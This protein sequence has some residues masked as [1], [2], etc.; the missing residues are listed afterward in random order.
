MKKLLILSVCAG[1]A[2][3]GCKKK[4]SAISTLYNHSVPTIILPDNHYYSI[5]VGGVLPAIEATAYDSFYH[6]ECAV[7]YDQSKLD[8]TIPDA[9]KVYATAQNKYGMMS[10][11]LLYVAVTD[12]DP[13]IDLSGLYARV[14]NDDTVM[15]TRLANGFYM[16][17]DVGANG[18]GDTTNIASAYFVQTSDV[19]LSMP[20]QDTKFGMLSG[21]GGFINMA[22]GD[23]TIEYVINNATFD[24]SIRL[25]KK[26]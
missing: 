18:S 2:F 23:T 15:V 10:S 19:A 9:Y 11:E 17:N 6:E 13:V 25:F 21:T 8:N 4:E 12:I 16:T 3:T 14:G 26:L 22:P 7:V 5:P 24:Q 1:L 20:E